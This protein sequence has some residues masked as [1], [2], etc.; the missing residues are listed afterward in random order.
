MC[1]SL[2]KTLDLKISKFM[3]TIWFLPHLRRIFALI[4]C[5][6]K[7]IVFLSDEIVEKVDWEEVGIFMFLSASRGLPRMEIEKRF[8]RIMKVRNS[9]F[10]KKHQAFHI[11]LL[12][13]RVCCL[14]R[15]FSCNRDDTSLFILFSLLILFQFCFFFNRNSPHARLNSNHEAWSYNKKKHKKIKA[16]RKSV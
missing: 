9:M 10:Q 12:N 6:I 1:L 14:P 4:D 13:F 3:M 16:Y 7:M 5:W 8:R 2:E 15:I 11:I